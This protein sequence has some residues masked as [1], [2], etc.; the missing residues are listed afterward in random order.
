MSDDET[1]VTATNLIKGYEKGEAFKPGEVKSSE[2]PDISEPVAKNLIS[3]FESGKVY[4]KVGDVASEKPDI[5]EPLAKNLISSFEKGDV[6]KPTDIKHEKPVSRPGATKNLQKVY[7]GIDAESK[8]DSMPMSP[9]SVKASST[10]EAKALT[11]PVEDA[12]KAAQ[13]QAPVQQVDDAKESKAKEP[14]ED[15]AKAA[16][17]KQ[18]KDDTAET[19]PADASVDDVAKVAPTTAPLKQD[20][21]EA[22]QGEKET[23]K[24]ALVVFAHWKRKAS[25]NGALLDVTESTLRDLGYNVIVS[26]LYA[27]GWNPAVS[28]NDL[29]GKSNKRKLLS[30]VC[31]C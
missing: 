7:E 25:F 6:S 17:A 29:G 14:G 28:F 20:P 10:D 3:S 5:H 19:T 23:R 9:S 11:S 18:Q 27:M 13:A 31:T 22:K 21:T 26:D 12:A 8:A 15:T 24:T 1:P 4:T 16:V 30:S 2:K